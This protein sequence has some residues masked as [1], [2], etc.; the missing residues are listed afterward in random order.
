VAIKYESLYTRKQVAEILA[1]SEKT[2]ER[3][4]HRGKLPRVELPGRIIRYRPSS[5]QS[6]IEGNEYILRPNQR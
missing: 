2:I 1:V 5:V 6:F 4:E 3:Y